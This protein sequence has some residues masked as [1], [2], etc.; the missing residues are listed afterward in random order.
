MVDEAKGQGAGGKARRFRLPE[1]TAR[2]ADDTFVDHL[3]DGAQG[4][5][6]LD[7]SPSVVGGGDSRSDGG[8][9]AGAPDAVD[10][11]EGGAKVQEAHVSGPPAARERGSQDSTSP[12]EGGA[13]EFEDFRRRW[14]KFLSE[15]QMRLCEIIFSETEA[16]GRASYETSSPELALALKKTKRYTFEVLSQLEEKGFI[17]REKI[18]E[19]KRPLGIRLWF[20]STPKIR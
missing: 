7:E 19:S 10:A 5:R 18:E 9:V 17:E 2:P 6:R 1:R 13:A 12:A 8:G 11:A 14:T 20:F 16:R 3:L 4:A 15:T